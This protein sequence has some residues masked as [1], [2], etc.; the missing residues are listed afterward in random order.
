MSIKKGR[1]ILIGAGPGDKGLI[2]VKGLEYLKQAEVVVYDRLVSQDILSLSPAKAEL[3]NVGKVMNHH[4]IPQHEINKIL[5]EKS[6][7]GKNV[8]RLKGGD[9]FVFGRGGE[10]LEL[11]KENNIDFEIIPG[12]TS[13]VSAL[14]YAGI[15]VT[16]RDFTSSIHFI[17]GH[18]KDG[19]VDN[20]DFK[21]L[22]NMNGTILFYMGVSTLNQ[23][24]DGLLKA[25]M[26]KDMPCCAVENG[27]RYNMRTMVSTLSN[28][29][30][31]AKKFNLRSPA[32]IAFGKV[33][34]LA[35]KFKWYTESKIFSKRVIALRHYLSKNILAD[36][37]KN[38]G[39]EVIDYPC[40]KSD[41]LEDKSLIEKAIKDI[42][43]YSTLIFT[44][45]YSVENFFKELF[46]SNKDS[47]VLF[48]KRICSLGRITSDELK[49]YCII[50]D[51]VSKEYTNESMLSELE[52][53]GVSGNIL[54]LESDNL[55]DSLADL[56]KSSGYK[57]EKVGTFKVEYLPFDYKLS[58]DE[59]VESGVIVAFTSSSVVD[60]FVK[61][62]SIKDL[63]KVIGV[64]IGEQTYKRAVEYGINVVKAEK[65]TIDSLIE[66]IKE[67]G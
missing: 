13:A 22:V 36:K 40:Y 14:A 39:A 61:G 16:H 60:G 42:D 18:A 51:I 9:P 44:S 20:I 28:I 66:K 46:V 49:K 52:S 50:S 64:C 35:D 53:I 34:S 19:L 30:E 63:S 23:L 27:T 37:L 58:L 47:R 32:V 29:V 41:E 65:A 12:I 17:T 33:C 48:N 11:L 67:M 25:G 62:N 24:A 54:V 56:L 43:N 21:S 38:L 45:K 8:V 26:D 15:P 5:L 4:N 3:I 6:L 7:E 10:E 31:D 57:V 1:V 55:S 59:C 2:T